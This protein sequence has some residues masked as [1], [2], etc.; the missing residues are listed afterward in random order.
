MAI[1]SEYRALLRGEARP[2]D[3]PAIEHELTQLWKATAED[4]LEGEPVVRACVLNLVAYAPSQDVAHHINE[5]ISQVSARH[6]SRSIVIV[7]GRGA[8]SAQ[9]RASISAHC[10]IAPEGGKQVCNEQ[11]TL[12]VSGPA[13]DELHG[14]VLPLLV[15]ELPVFLWW[16]DEPPLTGHLFRELLD[17]CDRLVV[18]SADFA[19]ERAE[20]ALVGL[21]R[22]VG[23]GG[24]AVS[25]LNWSRLTHWR[26]LVAQFF[27]APPG[28]QYL[29]KLD[30]VEVEIAS[31]H[32]REPYLTEGLLLV[33][34][35]ASRLGW[36][37]ENGRRSRGGVM[38]F[39]FRS[40]AGAVAVELRPKPA[41]PGEGLH[42]VRVG[43]P[44][45]ATFSLSRM[46]DDEKCVAVTAEIPEGGHSR[47]VCMDWPSEAA[48]LCEELEMQGRDT[49]FEEA[50][51]QAV[52]FMDVG[53]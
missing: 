7:A 43:A 12:H 25:D 20:R 19:P 1:P 8:R 29:D 31:R 40:A 49:V 39:G 42:S 13:V 33:G 38:A 44:G 23:E 50:L 17:S 52:R 18:D 22:L 34:W 16:H 36:A 24:V 9:L 47:V 10:Q 6:P 53:R 11:I 5:V 2:V 48:L 27:D 30:R 15:P 4:T 21:Q 14:T 35:L 26:E 51:A 32:G 46:P 45:S 3:V 41:H 28:R 37:L